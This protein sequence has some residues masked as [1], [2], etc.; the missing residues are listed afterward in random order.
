MFVILLIGV[1]SPSSPSQRWRLVCAQGAESSEMDY[2]SRK[3][4]PSEERLRE[5][6]SRVEELTS[7]NAR[8][9]KELR[10]LETENGELKS[11]PDYGESVLDDDL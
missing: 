8:L 1:H 5:L 6:D 11:W 9:K 2:G 7:E 3:D 4:A 10:K